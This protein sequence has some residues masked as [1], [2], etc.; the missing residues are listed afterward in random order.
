MNQYLHHAP[1]VSEK[2]TEVVIT[3]TG[4][5]TPKNSISNKELVKAFNSYVD[6]YNDENQEGI[7]QGKLKALEKSSENFIEKASGIKNRYAINKS[8]LLDP[9]RMKPDIKDRPDDEPSIQCEMAVEASLEAMKKA[10]VGPEDIG[11]VIL[12]CSFP[13]RSYPAVAIEVQNALK[14][15]EAFAFDMN[16][17]CASATFAIQMATDSIK[18]GS[19]KC[20]LIVN[21]E[22]CTGHLNYKSRDCHFIFG[23]ACTALIIQ[24]YDPSKNGDHSYKILSS[25]SFTSF[26]SNIRNN[27]GFLNNADESGIG[28]PD[29]VFYQQG[30]KVFKEVVPM[31]SNFILKHLKEN[32]V[33]IEMVK[34]FWLHQANDSMNRLIGKK[35]L[36]RDPL[37]K[38]TPLI[39]DDYA[40]TSSAGSII[41]FH[42]YHEDLAKN[43]LGIICAFGAGY[44]VGSVLIEKL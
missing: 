17:A 7:A 33:N 32:D 15:K 36:G 5:Y 35:I 2:M 11:M 3:G 1:P 39:L 40:N 34:R 41:A 6:L 27:F 25:K 16:V 12:A 26:S 24:K 23:D 38:E 10:K 22:V 21:P 31:V 42:K 14:I 44:S 19:V 9:K 29:K 43:D 20:A 8:G 4:L 28:K 13:Q 30:R 18:S 37:E